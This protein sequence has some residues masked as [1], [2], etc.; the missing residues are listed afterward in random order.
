MQLES[1][2]ASTTSIALL[3][4]D[5]ASLARNAYGEGS[6]LQMRIMVG[7]AG[8]SL[9]AS[10]GVWRKSPLVYVEAVNARVQ[11]TAVV[12]ERESPAAVVTDE[13]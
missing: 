13:K 7:F 1:L 11:T 6:N 4:A 9:L 3:P 12:E 5:L 10:L 2:F 8:A